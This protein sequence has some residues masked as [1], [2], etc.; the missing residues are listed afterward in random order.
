MGP[1]HQPQCAAA[2]PQYLQPVSLLLR[3]FLKPYILALGAVLILLPCVT[4]SHTQARFAHVAV[5][6]HIQLVC[7]L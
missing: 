1:V 4:V 6:L 7:C 3:C 2:A 5:M